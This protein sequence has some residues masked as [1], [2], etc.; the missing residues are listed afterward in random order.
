MEV[1]HLFYPRKL[2]G[3]RRLD[4]TEQAAERSKDVPNQRKK[5]NEDM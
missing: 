4:V 3:D 2:K 5:Q 1:Q